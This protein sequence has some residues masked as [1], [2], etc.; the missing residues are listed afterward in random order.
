VEATLTMRDMLEELE[1]TSF[2]KTT[3]GKGL[4]VAV[5]L[6]RGLDW[7]QLKDFSRAVAALAVE[8][9]PSSYTISPLK[10]NRDGK[11]FIDYLRNDRGSTAVAP[12]SVRARAHAPVAMPLPWSEV[13]PRLDP[14]RFTVETVPGILRRRRKDPWA[15]MGKL[16]QTIPAAALRA[17]G[18]KD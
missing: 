15:E 11:I 13:G 18:V 6:K 2:A 7:R 4:H 14:K 9:R 16:R 1:L 3:G 17:L 12:Y 8:A 5:P 10:R